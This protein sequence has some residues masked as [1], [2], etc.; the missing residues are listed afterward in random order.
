MV[1][2]S[3]SSEKDRGKELFRT[4]C[5]IFAH[6]SVVINID[7]HS[8]FCFGVVRAIEEAERQLS[9]SDGTLYC[10]GEIV[11]NNEEVERLGQLG[12]KVINMEEFK[13]LR[14]AKVL[15]RA[16]GE[17]PST[18]ELAKANQIELIDATCPI[19]LKLQQR[20]KSGFKEIQPQNGQVLIF[21]K[22]GH[23]EVIGLNGQ[24][25]N[26]A[27]VISRI[28]DLDKV[29]FSVPTLLYS[30]TTMNT[31]EY[32]AIIAKAQAACQEKKVSF[33]AV[34]S[35]CKSMSKRASQLRDFAHDHDAV[36]FVS[37]KQSSNGKY[38]YTICKDNNPNTFFVSS[39][40]EI[41]PKD[42]LSHKG[43]PLFGSIGICGATSTPMWLM[44]AVAEKIRSFCHL[45]ARQGT[46]L[47]T[48]EDQLTE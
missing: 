22:A 37:G 42:F 35:I 34:D 18:Y 9:Q 24:T 11:H 20:I 47:S 19:V 15:I 3:H 43:E 38:L 8:G 46:A 45:P 39:L 44:E 36:V 41:D 25:G 26:R 40:E 29:D 31:E 13:K 1:R 7:Q 33:H 28:E 5:R 32:A 16:H 23:A 21:G 30:Q 4:S 14:N 27:I 6:M 48:T 12:L 10:L 2:A 17:P